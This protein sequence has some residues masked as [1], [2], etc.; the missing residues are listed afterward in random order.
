MLN[1]INIID[2]LPVNAANGTYHKR[3]EP[4]TVIVIHHSASRADVTP[5]EIADYQIGPPDDFP[6]IAYHFL[7]YADGKIYQTNDINTLSFHA[8]DGTDSPL[9]TNRMGIGVCLVGDFTHAPPPA[10]QLAAARE[11]IAYLGLPF[12]PHREAY[13]TFTSCPGDTWDSWKELLKEEAKTMESLYSV[14]YQNPN[15]SKADVDALVDAGVTRIKMMIYPDT[16]LTMLPGWMEVVAR[17]YLND[18]DNEWILQGANGCDRWWSEV[19]LM[20]LANPNIKYVEGPNEQPHFTIEQLSSIDAFAARQ[21][22]HCNQVGKRAVIY[23]FSTGNPEMWHWQYLLKGLA[24]PNVILGLHEYRVQTS[25]W[26]PAANDTWHIG[27][28]I[29]STEAIKGFGG[30]VPDMMFGEC[31]IDLRGGADSDGWLAVPGMTPEKGLERLLDAEQVYLKSGYKIL[32]LYPFITKPYGWGSFDLATLNPLILANIKARHNPASDPIVDYAA[33]FV[34][35]QNQD[36]GLYKYIIGKGWDLSS[37]EFSYLGW[38]YEWAF[39]ASRKVRV[40]CRCQAPTWAVSEYVE[41]NN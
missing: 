36:A 11:L 19:F 13:N 10:A 28:F 31:N 24:S 17:P 7:V 35:A 12:I 37:G 2:Q 15:L 39:D 34:I 33:K 40:L 4:T 29:R 27:R 38:A 8:G 14:S 41:V 32:G 6:G 18:R 26:E 1:I 5:K 3:T 20:L 21:A 30:V 25:V 22:Y 23:N 9:N 16:K